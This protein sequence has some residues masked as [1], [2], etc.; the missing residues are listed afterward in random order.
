MKL[1][2]RSKTSLGSLV[3]LALVAC[4]SGSQN[5]GSKYVKT[6]TIGPAGGTIPISASDDLTLAGTSIT[7]PANALAANTSIS[8]G[9]SEVG[10]TPSGGKAAGPVVDFEPSGTVFTSPVTITIPATV[11]SGASKAS[12]FIEAV[13]ADNTARTIAV[14]SLAGGLATFQVSGFTRFGAW[15]GPADAGCGAGFNPGDLCSSNADC[16]CLAGSVCNGGHCESGSSADDAGAASTCGDAGVNPG[17]LCSSDADCACLPGTVCASGH[18]GSAPA[19]D[20]GTSN[21]DG[22]FNPG[23]LCTTNADC[24]CL[25]GSVC[26]SGHCQT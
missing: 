10:I 17:D 26:V 13:E 6:A 15:T 21:C 8:I 4:S 1:T 23:D 5:V 14:R 9:L 3:V 20:A 25:T 18:C 11:G 19:Q 12:V 7:I 16:A 24:V 22:G 2:M